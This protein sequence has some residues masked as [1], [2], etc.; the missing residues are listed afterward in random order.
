LQAQHKH[1]E[2]LP[3]FQRATLLAPDSFEAWF[4]LGYTLEAVP[5]HQPNELVCSHEQDCAD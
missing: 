2:A 1:A 4:S 3:F 5:K